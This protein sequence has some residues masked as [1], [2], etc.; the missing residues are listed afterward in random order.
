MLCDVN[1]K[2]IFITAQYVSAS[3]VTLFPSGV[4]ISDDKDEKNSQQFATNLDEN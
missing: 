1:D 3:M 4:F 2:E